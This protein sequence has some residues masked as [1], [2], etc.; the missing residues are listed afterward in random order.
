[1]DA[2]A[3]GGSWLGQEEL[4]SGIANSTSG[5][6]QEIGSIAFPLDTDAVHRHS[7]P[8]LTLALSMAFGFRFEGL[9]ACLLKAL[10]WWRFGC[11]EAE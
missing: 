6:T 8:R 11:L 4:A 9:Q 10:A 3:K 7:R 5:G 2:L 1:M